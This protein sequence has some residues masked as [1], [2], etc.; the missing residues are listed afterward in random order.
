M[1]V[2]TNTAEFH[3]QLRSLFAVLRILVRQ[4][5]QGPQSVQDYAAHLEG[6]I[7]AL[8]G[9]HEMLMRAPEEGVDFQEIVLAA[10][11]AQSVAEHQYQVAGPEVRIARDS[12]AALALAFH[13]LTVN[14]QEHGSLTCGEGWIEVTWNPFIEDGADWLSV[15][16][17]EHGAA[18]DLSERRRKGFGSE[19]LERMLP[20]ELGARTRLEWA[21]DGVQ[22]QLLIPA[23]AGAPVWRAGHGQ[24]A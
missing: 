21:R 3:R 15:R 14:A 10:L 23:R 8:A 4:T 13:E 16:W 6:R 7:G 2:Q 24:T 1:A 19:L 11:L 17:H 22:M 18:L 12:A 20:Y 5:T 9:A